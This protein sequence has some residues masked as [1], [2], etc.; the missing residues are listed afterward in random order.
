MEATEARRSEG[1]S[2]RARR[3]AHLMAFCSSKGIMEGSPDGNTLLGSSAGST[4][5][6]SAWL[7]RW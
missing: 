2:S 1:G 5:G 3:L 6:S 7:V 4:D